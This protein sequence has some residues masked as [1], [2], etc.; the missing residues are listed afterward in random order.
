[1][2]LWTQCYNTYYGR[3]LRA[4]RYK[5]VIVS[6]VVLMFTRKA[7]AYLGETAFTAHF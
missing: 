4:L 1:M 5:L 7:G 2:R 3:N 6:V